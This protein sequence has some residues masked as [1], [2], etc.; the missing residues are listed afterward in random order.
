MSYTHKQTV[1]QEREFARTGH[2]EYLNTL[3]GRKPQKGMP[4][5]ALRGVI[6]F[7]RI[8]HPADINAFF[9]WLNW[10]QVC[11]NQH[12]MTWKER[13]KAFQFF[14]KIYCETGLHLISATDYHWGLFKIVKEHE[15][16]V[17]PLDAWKA[18]SKNPRV[19]FASICRHLLC[20][21][22][23]PPV[24]ENALALHPYFTYKE[25]SVKWYLWIGRGGN[26]SKC[27]EVPIPFHKKAAHLLF[28]APR[29]LK[30]FNALR[31][32]QIRAM[33]GSATLARIF[34]TF[35]EDDEGAKI[36]IPEETFFALARIFIRGKC[37]DRRFIEKAFE[38][39]EWGTKGWIDLPWT[40]VRRWVNIEPPTGFHLKGTTL[41]SLKRRIQELEDYKSHLSA[42]AE[43]LR[44]ASEGRKQRED[45]KTGKRK[46]TGTAMKTITLKDKRGKTWQITELT[47]AKELGREGQK[48]RHCVFNM[49]QKCLAGQNSVFS[50][51]WTRDHLTWQKAAT[52]M[53]S[54]KTG[55]LV[56]IKGKANREPTDDVKAV[57]EYWRKRHFLRHLKSKK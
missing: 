43:M 39:A 45:R 36:P 30:F 34:A 26:L 19:L 3:R 56:E 16:W 2:E 20:Q 23:V 4:F 46:W 8:F 33:G 31:W 11:A 42:Q 44:K 37:T 1:L 9:P 15:N 47:N 22:P 17:R 40:A 27:P 21:Y 51:E 24:L 55:D 5:R 53:I 13:Q 12:E 14:S 32:A 29:N 54:M 38:L 41:D 57:H 50:I 25:A 35:Y 6:L 10:L 48:M 18:T 7:D 52:F 49:W 28:Q